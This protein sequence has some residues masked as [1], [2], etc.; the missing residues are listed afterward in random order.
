MSSDHLRIGRFSN[1]GMVYLV[2]TVTAARQPLFADFWQAR[3][4]VA[5]MQRLH[6]AGSVTSLAWVLMPNHLHWL[7]Q[8]GDAGTLAQVMKTFKG[9]SAQ[10]VNAA[11]KH[12]GA[13]WQHS[14]YRWPIPSARCPSSFLYGSLKP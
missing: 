6:D 1:P 8:L 13:V 9:G 11:S 10:A 3:A 12:Q 7:F 4:V 14:R 2:T 5:Q